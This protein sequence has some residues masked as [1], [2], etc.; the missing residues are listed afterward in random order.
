MRSTKVWMFTL[1][2]VLAAC[3][4]PAAQPVAS[5]TSLPIATISPTNTPAAITPE[6]AA[7][8]TLEP[9][10]PLPGPTAQPTAESTSSPLLTGAFVKEEVLAFGSFTLDPTTGALRFSDDFKVS[11]GPDLVVALSGASD[12]TADYVTFS[13][14][15]A[16]S[17]YL[18]LGPL[19][20]PSGA[21]EY[22]VPSGADLSLYNTVVV[23]CQSFDVAF[24]AAPLHP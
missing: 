14:S 21:Q 15:V 20:S 24:A 12:L 2:F 6:V 13:N 8:P 18:K 23:W 10:T 3:S 11:T 1:V 4:S 7:A 17:P 16:N 9:A 19:A 5:V 22:V